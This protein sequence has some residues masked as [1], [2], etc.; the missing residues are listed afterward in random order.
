MENHHG[1]GRETR[2]LVISLERGAEI[3]NE[4][5]AVVAKRFM[6]TFAPVSSYLG[7]I[8]RNTRSPHLHL[9]I[10]NSDGERG[11]NLSPAVLSKMQDVHE[12]SGGI[13]ESGK[14]S[15]GSILAKLTDAQ[16]LNSLTPHEIE[17]AIRSGNLG[18]GRRSKAGIVTSVVFNGRRIRLA[19]AQ[20]V[21]AV[22]TGQHPIPGD[23]TDRQIPVPGVRLEHGRNLP[24]EHSPALPGRKHLRRRSAG[25]LVARTHAKPSKTSG[26][27]PGRESPSLFAPFPGQ[28]SPTRPQCGSHDVEIPK[29]L[30]GPVR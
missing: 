18:V 1:R 3:D 17:L 7:A 23:A 19:T 21:A 30:G 15:S 14:N 8:D 10:C 2:H 5:L 16:H 20:R 29:N 26:G 27:A 13:L 11:L 22:A 25:P 28:D 12:W 9:V 4:R 24:A 6:A